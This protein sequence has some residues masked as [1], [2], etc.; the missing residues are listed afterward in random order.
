MN[1]ESPYDYIKKHAAEK[2][3]DEETLRKAIESLS[4]PIGRVEYLQSGN[5]KIE[6][7]PFVLE[8]SY[9][10]ISKEVAESFEKHPRY[11]E[12]D[13]DT[14]FELTSYRLTRTDKNISL[15]LD[16]L[17]PDNY[18]VYFSPTTQDW[19]SYVKTS[20]KNGRIVLSDDVVTPMILLQL[21]H[22]A[23]HVHEKTDGGKQFTE[24]DSDNTSTIYTKD[25]AKKLLSERNAW[26]FALRK[27]KPFLDEDKSKGFAISKNDTL[28][29]AKN[30]ALKSYLDSIKS[31]IN[32][33]VAMNH[34]AHDY[35]YMFEDTDRFD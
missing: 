18:K 31:D 17:I 22:E 9:A 35:D 24:I 8:F 27:I 19:S 12:P 26:A 16:N 34:F 10:K 33:R 25:L 1:P 23:G 14:L 20:D 5:I 13:P 28:I 3:A 11:K 30:W 6:N 29:L 2:I 15:T 32:D 21:L 4:K 7:Q